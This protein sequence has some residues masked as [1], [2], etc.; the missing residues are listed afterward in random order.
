MN[1]KELFEKYNNF[2]KVKGIGDSWLNHIKGYI[3]I[4]DWIASA[5]IYQIAIWAIGIK[6][7]YWLI[8]IIL[9][10]KFYIMLFINWYAGKKV[11]KIGLQEAQM[12]VEA[13]NDYLTQYQKD[14]KKTVDNIADKVGAEKI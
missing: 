12:K 7:P 11:I 10:S 2:I 1:K 4:K 6:F 14:I 8:I 3:P 13:K 5:S 9:I